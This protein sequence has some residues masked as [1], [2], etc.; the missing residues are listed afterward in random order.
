MAP[1]GE[2]GLNEELA[3]RNDT[4]HMLS[5]VLGKSLAQKSESVNDGPIE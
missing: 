3:Y 4:S 1:P 2:P 5:P